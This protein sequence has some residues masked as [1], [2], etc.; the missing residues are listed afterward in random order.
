MRTSFTVAWSW[1]RR[2]FGSRAM[3]RSRSYDGSDATVR[4]LVQARIRQRRYEPVVRFEFAPG[5]DPA[6]S[7]KSAADAL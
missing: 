2:W 4:E 7:A 3:R 1:A 6:H 5:A